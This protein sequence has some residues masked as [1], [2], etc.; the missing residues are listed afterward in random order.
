MILGG[1]LLLLCLVCSTLS[2]HNIAL[3]FTNSSDGSLNT[4]CNILQ[5]HGWCSRAVYDL[6]W[7]K[8]NVHKPPR[9][10]G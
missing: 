2:S 3:I 4:S 1:E 10:P 7:D 6:A 9:T 8:W 5:I